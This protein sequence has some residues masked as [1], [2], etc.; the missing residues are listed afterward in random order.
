MEPIH[1]FVGF[2]LFCLFFCKR[3]RFSTQFFYCV[4]GTFVY[5]LASFAFAFGF[6]RK[7][8]LQFGKSFAEIYQATANGFK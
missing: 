3:A 1:F 2:P 7:K 4:F 5:A 6:C 8:G